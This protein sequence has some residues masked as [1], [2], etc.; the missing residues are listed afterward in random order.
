M[1]TSTQIKTVTGKIN[2]IDVT[3]PAGTTILEAARMSGIE[4]PNLCYQPLLRPCGS[5]R[6]C[7]VEI[8]G[9]RGGLIESCATP[10]GEGMEVLTHSEPVVDARQFVLQMY[11]IDHALD[12]PTCD[13]SGECYLQDNT[14]LHNINSNPYRRPKMAKAYEHFSDTIDYKWD[15]CIMCTR[16]TRVC[17]EMIGVTAIEATARAAEASISPAFGQD[18]SSTLCTN[19]GMC[20]AVCPVGALTDRHFAHHPWELDT[21]ETICGMC[22]GG[23]TINVE[24]NKGVVRRVS[25]LWD[26]GVNHGYTCEHGK[27]GHEQQQSPDRQ[28]YPRIKEDGNLFEV[29]WD[30]AIDTVAESLAHFQGDVFAALVSPDDTNEEA[31]AVQQFTRAVMRTNNVDRHLTAS[32]IAVEAATIA[33]L[34]RDVSHT[35][36]LQEF[37]SDVKSVL[38]VGPNVTATTRVPSY[39]LYQ[40]RIYREAKTVVVSEDEFPLG[41]RAEVWLRPNPG[42]TVTLLNG[43]ARQIFEQG[44]IAG[45]ASAVAG[46]AASLAPF[47]LAYV[48]EVTGCD[49]EKIKRAAAIYATG[50]T[51]RKLTE[52]NYVAS[53]IYNTAAHI[54]TENLGHGSDDPSA[55]TTACNNLALLTGNL[56]RPGGGVA[57]MRGPANYQGVTD[58]GATPFNYPG[59]GNVFTATERERFSSLWLAR[60][61]ERAKTRNGFLPVRE[62]PSTAGKSLVDMIPAIESGEIKAMYIEGT[63]EGRRDAIN[64][65][66]LDALGKLEFLVVA[67]YYWSPLAEK[68][69]VVLPLSTSLEKDGTFTSLD[70]TVQRV[71][72][73]V[74]AMGES[75]SGTEIMSMLSQRMGYGMDYRHAS[76]V[77]TEIAQVAQSYGGVT[78]ARLERGGLSSPVESYADKG[79][80]VLSID[81]NG[82]ASLNPSFVTVAD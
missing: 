29:T 3:V 74:P 55:V 75:K 82:Y 5:C 8:L 59:G 53:L 9:K 15:R 26:R 50:G 13:K 68:A 48:A 23:C 71:R 28:F 2:G 4:V 69:H 44:L 43:L 1:S 30:Q 57:S 6:I 78:Y 81:G 33:S 63:L 64:P 47:T 24:S 61:A 25:H 79:T 56:G 80:P 58:L 42:T 7:T 41:W 65:R 76:A 72:A 32:Q 51:E 31:Y 36:N 73:A 38:V 39:W 27:W 40:S 21:T 49:P 45:D 67:D 54:G 66:L 35:N 22:D 16:C 19:C 12:C 62:L 14:Y 52:G 37:F 77:M 10:L 60:W 11:L 34:G 46:F 20:V 18:L 17:D 70:R